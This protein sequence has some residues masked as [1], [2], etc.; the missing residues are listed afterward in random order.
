MRTSA[1]CDESLP[2]TSAS[3]SPKRA[4][5]RQQ[6]GRHEREDLAGVGQVGGRVHAHQDEVVA[7]RDHVRVHLL[8]ALRGGQQVEAEL[9]ALGGDAHGVLGGQRRERVLGPGGADVVRLVDHDQHRLAPRAQVPQALEHRFGHERLLLDVSRASRDR[10]P[11]RAPTGSSSAS[12]VEPGSS[13]AHTPQRVHAEVARALGE[14]R[15]LGAVDPEELLDRIGARVVEHR[16]EFAVLV[17]VANGVEPQRC[18]P[19]GRAELAEAQAQAVGAA[20]PGAVDDDTP[21]VAA[22]WRAASSGSTP[23]RR[24]PMRTKSELG[25]STTMRRLVSSS[26]CSSRTPSA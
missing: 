4:G 22:A 7:L 11:A 26:S 24:S 8:R 10:R 16:R 19:T 23:G 13:R 18:G 21:L 17:A 25:S 1:G 6:A 14:C 3:P 9:A 5:A 12:S 2:A 15:G 20:R